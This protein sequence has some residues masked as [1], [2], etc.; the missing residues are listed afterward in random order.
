MEEIQTT[1]YTF[2][3]MLDVWFDHICPEI[4]VNRTRL[5]GEQSMFGAGNIVQA[6]YNIINYTQ[7]DVTSKISNHRNV[8]PQASCS[9]HLLKRLV[10][11]RAVLIYD[12][13]I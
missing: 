8:L 5:H 6:A 9:N 4:V 12:R 11:I 3:N 13:I 2:E 10:P 1:E 7:T